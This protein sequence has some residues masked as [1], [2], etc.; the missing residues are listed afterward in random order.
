MIYTRTDTYRSCSHCDVRWSDEIPACW[1]CGKKGELQ[2][3]PMVSFG[4]H[5]CDPTLAHAQVGDTVVEID[6]AV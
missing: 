2:T 1:V 4:A 3:M 6:D 5:R